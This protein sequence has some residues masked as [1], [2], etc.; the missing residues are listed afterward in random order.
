MEKKS[1]S[2]RSLAFAAVLAALAIVLGYVEHLI[3]LP[4]GI[5]GIKLGLANLAV[6]L[7]LYLLGARHAFAVNAVRI[8]VSALLFGSVVSLAYSICGGLVS[9][10]LMT[11]AKKY[12]HFSCVGVS[13]IGGITHNASQLC[14]AVLLVSNLRIAFY[15]PVLIAVGAVTGAIIGVLSA[16]LISNPPLKKLYQKAPNTNKK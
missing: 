12:L 16:S 8:A 1:L 15:L 13:I 11:L 3:P 4:I 6:V 7:S 14:V 5:Y 10:L 9:L 2:L